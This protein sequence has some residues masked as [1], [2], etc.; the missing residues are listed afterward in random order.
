MSN[1]IRGEDTILGTALAR[2]IESQPIRSTP[3]ERS[4]VAV[5]MAGGGRSPL[6]PVLAAAAAVVLGLALGTALLGQRGTDPGGVATQPS[7]SPT[8]TGATASPPS[9]TPTQRGRTEELRVFLARDQLP[10]AAVRMPAAV[11]EGAS[12]EEYI[13][14][15]LTVLASAEVDG[16]AINALSGIR[17]PD[18]AQ[19]AR[20]IP[21]EA[22]TIAGDLATVEFDI[23]DWGARGSAQSQALLQQLV[24]TITE[25]PGIRRALIKEQGKDEAVIDQLVIDEPLTREDVLPY[26]GVKTEQSVALDDDARQSTA[27]TRIEDLVGGIRFVI[28]L[29]ATET[30][31][32]GFW[33]P[34]L[35]AELAPSA[36]T[37][38]VSVK[39]ILTL[40]LPGATTSTDGYQPTGDVGPEAFMGRQ[41]VDQSPLR[42]VELTR[43]AGASPSVRY[44]LGLDDA[45]PWRISLEPGA[46]RGTMRLIVDI[47][48][49]PQAISDSVAVY[50]PEPGDEVA[51]AFTL[52]GTARA[53][54]AHVSWRIKDSGDREVATG[55]V[56]ASLGTSP[57]WGTFTTEVKIPDNVSG[58]VTLEVFWPSPRDGADVGR[59]A[60]PL[61]VR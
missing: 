19:G 32:G 57:V 48:G 9:P 47:G 17:W 4:R 2:A 53:F 30:P 7:P 6:F 20:T 49:H 36:D 58:V 51:R 10:P 22:V 31:E 45:R 27:T 18:S 16:E 12:R 38:K 54:E 8:P 52:T 55:F 33:S 29:R 5:R 60:I 59:V 13:A 39:S 23:A 26:E 24:Y 14:A 35:A 44:R 15:R 25:E 61:R 41:T 34:R 3:F 28:E 42:W 1:E 11:N 40:E 46:E 50:G 56:T 37:P 43:T 21:R